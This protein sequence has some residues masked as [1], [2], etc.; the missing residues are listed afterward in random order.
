MYLGWSTE[1][2]D[3]PLTFLPTEVFTSVPLE[4]A[5]PFCFY[6]SNGLFRRHDF[7]LA[8]PYNRLVLKGLW[9]VYHRV[10][11]RS[12]RKEVALEAPVVEKETMKPVSWVTLSEVVGSP[13]VKLDLP[14][15]LRVGD[16]VRLRFVLRRLVGGRSEVL[17]VNDEFRVGGVILSEG[18]QTLSVD[19][20]GKLP[21][22][23]AVRREPPPKRQ[24]PPARFP[25]TRL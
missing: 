20:V 1:G 10:V 18:R 19:S 25:P 15:P 14:V 22:W 24:L 9:E 7:R 13:T 4:A 16:R 5:L 6:L 21:A 17:S 2:S 8:E 12:S 3:P 23:K 11:G